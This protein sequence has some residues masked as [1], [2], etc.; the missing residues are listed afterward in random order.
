MPSNWTSRLILFD[1]IFATRGELNTNF[2]SLWSHFISHIGYVIL[3][4]Y[5]ETGTKHNCFVLK[6]SELLM[7]A[8]FYCITGSSLHMRVGNLI[9]PH[10]GKYLRWQIKEEKC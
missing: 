7:H 5:R 2:Y 1:T 3:H 6:P 8:A 9:M 10:P 4:T